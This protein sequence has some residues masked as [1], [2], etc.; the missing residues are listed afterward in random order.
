MH[1]KRRQKL[2]GAW[3]LLSVLLAMGIFAANQISIENAVRGRVRAHLLLTVDEAHFGDNGN[4]TND[5]KALQT[6]GQQ[7]NVAINGLVANRWYSAQKSCVV[8]LRSI[9]HVPIDESPARRSI[10]FGLLRNQLEREVD[11][12]V[13]CAPNWW[14]AV[15]MAGCLGI[16]FLAIGYCLRPPLSK[17]HRQWINYLLER[18]YSGAAAFDAVSRY[19]AEQLVLRPAQLACL[20][21]LHD[22]LKHNFPRV[23]DLLADQRVAALEF[24][25]VDWFL[26]GLQ[27]DPDNL[28]RALDL[29]AAEDTLAFDLPR[30]TVSVRGLAVPMSG[31]PLFYYAWYGMRRLSGD[32]WITNPASNRPDPVLG[33][34]LIDLMSRFDGHA[35]AINE[36]E[37]SGLRAKTLDQNRSKIKDDLVAV[38]GQNLAQ[39]YLFDADK[40]LNGIRMRYRLQLDARHIHISMG[41]S[42]I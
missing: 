16:L 11:V 36:L 18:G 37:R 3:L 25:Q 14:V 41:P 27:G 34:E 20:E 1:S 10:T 23:V 12:G 29:A 32:G 31:T 15:G 30:M 38:L 19:D 17:L 13:S 5:Q 35:K 33:R 8:G 9:D 26:Q 7:V 4:R 28:N 24:A 40:P 6:I 2:V 21:Q 42:E 39:A 22:P